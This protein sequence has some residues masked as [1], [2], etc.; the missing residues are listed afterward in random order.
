MLKPRFATAACRITRAPP[1]EASSAVKVV[2]MF[3]PT[4][5]AAACISPMAPPWSITSASA[6]IAP[7]DWM[8]TVITSPASA[9]A[10]M[11]QSPPCGSA[12]G[13]SRPVAVSIAVCISSSP[14]SSRQ[15]P[16]STCPTRATA[17]RPNS[18]AR[19][20]GSSPTIA[21]DPS[22]SLSPSRDTSQPFAVVPILA[23]NRI[24]IAW[25][26]VINPAPTNPTVITV[27]ALEDW[28]SAVATAP[29]STPRSGVVVNRARI[30]RRFDPAISF[31]ARVMASIP[32]RNMPTPP[33]K[34]KISFVMRPFP[35]STG[36]PAPA[37]QASGTIGDIVLAKP[38]G[39]V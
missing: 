36:C 15:S 28:I 19:L 22:C 8:I 17:P 27:V 31:S 18:T 5:S 9:S 29:V 10:S 12:S 3:N 13:F 23:P 33:I 34:R 32:M 39:G 24:P 26:R 38:S 25:G 16:A 2:P 35:G 4:T 20:A 7:E 6:T 14:V 37:R 1:T 21:S 11:P 30:P